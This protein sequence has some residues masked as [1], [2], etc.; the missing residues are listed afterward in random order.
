[1]A[2]R[3]AI[4]PEAFSEELW[5]GIAGFSA[6]EVSTTGRVRRCRPGSNMKAG[7]ILKMRVGSVG[8]F[9][10]TLTNDAGRRVTCLVHRLVAQ[11]FLP[12]A[13]CGSNFVLHADDVKTDNRVKNLR[14]GTAR[15]NSADALLNGCL[16]VGD[17]HPCRMKPWTRPRGERHVSRKLSDEDV[18]TIMA[19]RGRQ[20]D[21][22]QAF[23]VN[24][25]LVWR[26]KH[27][28]VWKHI[29]NPAYGAMLAAGAEADGAAS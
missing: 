10:V 22:A 20:R 18:R 15:E 7:C 21:I 3:I 12:P 2:S 4:D 1:M 23:G 8:Y 24:Q 26:I 25:A 28:K 14:W 9:K 11:A 6:Y 27:G 13:P 17:A 5:A 16:A 19:A 29:T